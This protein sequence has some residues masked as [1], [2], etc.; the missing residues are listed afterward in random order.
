M[1][2]Q[3]HAPSTH[4][5]EL[6]EQLIAVAGTLNSPL[7]VVVAAKDDPEDTKQ[8]MIDG[9]H[10]K[11]CATAAGILVLLR[12]GFADGALARWRSLYEVELIAHF[13]ADHGLSTAERY[14]ETCRYQELGSNK[15]DFTL[16][17]Y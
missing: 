2:T 6:L 10:G 13:I 5:L 11:G 17:Q 15:L 3:Q 12:A 8:D 1:S 16:R 7:G 9:L 4:P 14:A